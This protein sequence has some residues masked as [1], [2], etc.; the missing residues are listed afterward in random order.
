MQVAK[1]YPPPFN[2]GKLLQPLSK[3][4]IFLLLP[5]LLAGCIAGPC[6]K[7]PQYL[8]IRTRAEELARAPTPILPLS[9]LANTAVLETLR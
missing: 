6:N 3:I 2:L 8:P 9:G 5:S 7:H 1:C 4:N